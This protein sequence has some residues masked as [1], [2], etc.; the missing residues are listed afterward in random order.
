MLGDISYEKSIKIIQNNFRKTFGMPETI[1]VVLNACIKRYIVLCFFAYCFLT[2]MHFLFFG[3]KKLNY[4][5]LCY[6]GHGYLIGIKCGT[7]QK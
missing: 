6:I 3:V 1:R 2:D 4:S 7:E 5:Y